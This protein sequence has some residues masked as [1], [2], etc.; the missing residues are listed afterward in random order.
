MTCKLRAGHTKTQ[1]DGS[2]SSRSSSVDE[3][4]ADQFAAAAPDPAPAPAPAPADLLPV[5]QA[6]PTSRGPSYEELEF[7]LVFEF[8]EL[9]AQRWERLQDIRKDLARDWRLFYNGYRVMHQDA[10]LKIAKLR[11][12]GFPQEAQRLAGHLL[13]ECDIGTYEIVTQTPVNT[14]C[15]SIRGF[16]AWREVPEDTS[17][18]AMAQRAMRWSDD[19]V[20]GGA[21]TLAHHGGPASNTAGPESMLDG[22]S[23]TRARSSLTRNLPGASAQGSDETVEEEV[24]GCFVCHNANHRDALVPC[25]RCCHVFHGGCVG[26]EKTPQSPWVCASCGGE[27]VRHGPHEGALVSSTELPVNTVESVAGYRGSLA[28]PCNRSVS[29]SQARREMHWVCQTKSGVPFILQCA[30]P[31][32]VAQSYE[33]SHRATHHTVPSLFHAEPFR[34][35]FALGHF[36]EAHGDQDLDMPNMVLKYGSEGKCVQCHSDVW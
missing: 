5:S 6:P 25:E 3:L 26:L 21:G 9:R 8:D 23:A 13:K 20:G 30:C 18:A 31:K 36:Q 4:A 11:E 34:D 17:S 14:E 24:R 7:Q 15:I 22:T 12:D 16:D 29:L 19:G 28:G 33:P 32:T 2:R 10:Q 35:G 1:P 27:A